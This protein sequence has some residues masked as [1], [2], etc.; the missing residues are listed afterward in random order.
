MTQDRGMEKRETRLVSAG[1]LLTRTQL[2][3][4]QVFGCALLLFFRPNGCRLFCFFV[5]HI[6]SVKA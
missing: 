5:P 2:A 6:Q 3:N 1:K 4:R